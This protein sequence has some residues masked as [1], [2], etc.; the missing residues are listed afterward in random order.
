M[1]QGVSSFNAVL[2]KAIEKSSLESDWQ[3]LELDDF[4][5]EWLQAQED[6]AKKEWETFCKTEVTSDEN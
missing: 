2:N 1:P 3:D 6:S 4:S 5:E